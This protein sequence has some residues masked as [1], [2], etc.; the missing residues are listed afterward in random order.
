MDG[1]SLCICTVSSINNPRC[2]WHGGVPESPFVIMDGWRLHKPLSP[3]ESASARHLSPRWAP[4]SRRDTRG[5]PAPSCGHRGSRPGFCCLQSL[6]WLGG[7]ETAGEL[8]IGFGLGS[9]AFY[10]RLFRAFSTPASAF[11]HL[12]KEKS[13]GQMLRMESQ[14]GQAVPGEALDL[15]KAGAQLRESKL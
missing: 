9:L 7:A 4:D 15:A 10:R 1:A 11:S 12:L 6:S 5:V 2:A 8:F 3:A 14:R 13:T